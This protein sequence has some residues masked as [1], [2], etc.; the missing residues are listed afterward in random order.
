MTKQTIREQTEKGIAFGLAHEMATNWIKKTDA[1]EYVL[2]NYY[3][4]VRERVF[5]Q[6]AESKQE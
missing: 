1:L 4:E 6:E 3:D 5:E 2:E